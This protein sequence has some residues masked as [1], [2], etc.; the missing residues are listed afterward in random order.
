M[1]LYSGISILFQKPTKSPPNFFS[2]ADPF[3]IDTWIALAIAF[4]VVSLSFFLLG[5]I[6]PDEWNNP[7]PCVEE[8]EY[9][10]NQFTMSNSVW[11]A[12]GAML[13]QGS[14]IAPM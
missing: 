7:Y 12:T 5:R 9:L 10:I 1:L 8:P 14:E 13:Q 6:C 3:A 4:V 11:F 2:F